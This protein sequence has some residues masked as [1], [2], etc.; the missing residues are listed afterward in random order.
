MVFDISVKGMHCAH[1][2]TKVKKAL[3][4]TSGVRHVDVRLDAGIA[5]VVGDVPRDL[6][7]KAIRSAG[8]TV[9]LN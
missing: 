3:Q 1:C 6:L 7:E 4:A 8:Y 2:C 5:R 9:P